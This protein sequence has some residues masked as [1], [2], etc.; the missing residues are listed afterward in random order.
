VTASRVLRARFGGA[1]VPLVFAP[2]SLSALG[3]RMRAAGL[4][5]GPCALVT[6]RTVEG[7]YGGHARGALRRSGF[8]PVTMLVVPP[9]ERSKSLAAAAVLFDRLAAAGLERGRPI[10]ALG[11]GVVGDLAGFVA[12][13]WLR[14]VPLV[15]VPTTVLA[16]LDSSI[17]GKVGVDLES[18]KNL[19]GAFH[20]PRLVLLD[21][22]LLASLP[23]RHLR[24]GLAEAAKVG[25]TLDRRLVAL[26][27]QHAADLADGARTPRARA[28][29]ARVIERAVRAKVRVV[30]ADERD[31]GVRQVLN[32][33][34]TVGHALEALGGYRRWLHG[35]AVALGM[36]VA[37]NAAVRRGTLAPAV[38]ER[39]RRLLRALG[40]PVRL[41][42]GVSARNVLAFMRLDKKNVAGAP[43]FVLTTRIGVAS[44]GQPLERSEVLAAL[45]DAGAER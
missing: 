13:T 20:Q 42:R 22:R 16:Q 32:Y 37:A 4:A 17:G 41:P 14:G 7:L 45:Q 5:P 18:G 12:A 35:E 19:V 6:D 40:L 1:T 26:L 10:V 9:G 34:H 29:L 36:T 24:S 23:R 38:A 33:G 8:A 44:F 25:F 11:G 39:Q 31:D 2:G 28:A 27:E 30:A 3:A 21:A 15:H 43:R